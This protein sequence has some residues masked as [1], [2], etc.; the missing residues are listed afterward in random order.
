MYNRDEMQTV[1]VIIPTYNRKRYV[2]KAIDSV[3]LQGYKDCEIIVIDDGSTD[4]TKEMLE[5]YGNRITYVYQANSGVSA[6][7]NSG[8]RRANGKWLAFTRF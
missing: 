5:V 3:V 2:V 1:S 4:N 8:I 7:R 6:A